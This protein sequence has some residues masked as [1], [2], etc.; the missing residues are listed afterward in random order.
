MY[1]LTK[2]L[3][4]V[5]IGTHKPLTIEPYNWRKKASVMRNENERKRML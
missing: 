1:L 4:G 2:I 5:Y 3:F